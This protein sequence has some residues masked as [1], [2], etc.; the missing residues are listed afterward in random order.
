VALDGIVVV[1]LKEFQ[2]SYNLNH[3]S[4]VAYDDKVLVS[5]VNHAV[6]LCL[7]VMWALVGNDDLFF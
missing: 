1:F 3:T 5:S 4:T 7:F 6:L 2:S